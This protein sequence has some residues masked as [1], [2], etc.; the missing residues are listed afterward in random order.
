MAFYNDRGNIF[1]GNV[2]SHRG[3]TITDIGS[4]SAY[5]TFVNN[6]F[7]STNSKIALVPNDMVGR[8][9][10]LAFAAYGT[11]LL[12]W[13]IVEAN[14]AYDYEVDFAAGKQILIP[15]V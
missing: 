14:N 10:L 8:P 13:L 1:K 9:D 5:R 7:D 6:V 15:Q 11:E 4:S 3:K 2:V 12:W